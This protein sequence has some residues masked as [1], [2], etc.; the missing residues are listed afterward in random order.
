MAAF[1]HYAFIGLCIGLVWGVGCALVLL[2]SIYL[3]G[4]RKAVKDSLEPE[5]HARYRETADKVRRSIG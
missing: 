5:K 4:Y 3:A 1:G 2:Y